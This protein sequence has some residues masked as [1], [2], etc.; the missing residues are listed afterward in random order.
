MCMVIFIKSLGIKGK[1][2]IPIQI[3]NCKVDRPKYINIF[4]Y[5]IMTTTGEKMVSRRL[6]GISRMAWVGIIVVVVVV[7]AI[8]YYYYTI[9]AVPPAPEKPYKGQH[10][11]VLGYNSPWTI[12]LADYIHEFEEE[13]GAIVTY[14]HRCAWEMLCE[15]ITL[16]VVSP[17]KADWDIWCITGDWRGPTFPYLYPM[18]EFIEDSE[19]CN[20]TRLAL[21]DFEPRVLKA[22]LFNGKTV[23]LA[24]HM[25]HFFL[26]YRTDL[27]EKY[28]IKPGPGSTSTWFEVIETAKKLTIDE[29]GDGKIDIYG[30]VTGMAYADPVTFAT[31]GIMQSFGA[32]VVS[33]KTFMPQANTPEMKEFLKFVCE[34]YKVLPPESIGWGWAE[35]A[36]FFQT[37]KA[38]MIWMLS[39]LGSTVANPEKSLVWDKVAFMPAPEGPAGPGNVAGGE[40]WGINADSKV[41]ELAYKWIEWVCNVDLQREIA[42][43][44]P[45]GASV[46][47][48]SILEDPEMIEKFPWY[49]PHQAAINVAWYAPCVLNWMQCVEVIANYYHKAILGEMSVDE[50]LDACQEDLMTNVKPWEQAVPGTEI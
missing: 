16:D 7:A 41:P 38:A 22:G 12:T 20:E 49:P 15:Q 28:G 18:D 6:V 23:W 37:G 11:Y 48:S 35:S 44:N 5:K 2:P 4:R 9:M 24:P 29:N 13:T 43:V 31:F 1:T 26:A 30:L 32:E 39:E 34:L 36:A 27:F 17:G 46:C 21:D 14:D 42:I 8:G 47:R 25:N 45:D 40:G 10:L 3:I 50:A 33:A 19:V